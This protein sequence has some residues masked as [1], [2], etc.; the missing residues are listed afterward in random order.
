M[1]KRALADDFGIPEYLEVAIE[2]LALDAH[3]LPFE[4]GLD[5]RERG[6]RAEVVDDIVA[7]P[8]EDRD[9]LHLCENPNK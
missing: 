6:R 5:V 9:V 1:S 3:A 4:A 8:V 7:H 2:R